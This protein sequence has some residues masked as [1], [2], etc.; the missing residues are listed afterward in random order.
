MYL[1]QHSTSL[2]EFFLIFFRAL[3]T[4]ASVANSF[5]YVCIHFFSVP[6][7][8]YIFWKNGNEPLT[9]SFFCCFFLYFRWR[10]KF[11]IV[12]AFLRSRKYNIFIFLCFFVCAVFSLFSLVSNFMYFMLFMEKNRTQ[13]QQQ[14]PKYEKKEYM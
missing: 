8:L 1:L 3:P 13:K 14:Q 12:V 11:I 9:L 4:A 5:A 7:F 10:K 2:V 6:F